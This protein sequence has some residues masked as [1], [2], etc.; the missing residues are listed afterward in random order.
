MGANENVPKSTW[1]PGSQS[2][3]PDISPKI[4]SITNY[5]NC[6]NFRIMHIF[7]RAVQ[8]L[9]DQS[10]GEEGRGEVGTPNVHLNT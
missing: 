8:V 4:A 7:L 2:D 1:L 3:L 6:K 10:S 9:C 5:D